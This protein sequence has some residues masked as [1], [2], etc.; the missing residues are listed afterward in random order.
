MISKYFFHHL[1][2]HR[3]HFHVYPK[4]KLVLR[5]WLALDR[6]AAA[7]RRVFYSFM[8]TT[9]DLAIGG[10]ILI[11]FFH[12]H[13]VIVVGI[14]FLLLAGILAVFSYRRYVGVR[15]HYHRLAREAAEHF[16]QVLARRPVSSRKNQSSSAST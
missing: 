3:H 13:W 9:L 6:T 11:R 1:D 7:N 4:S 2:A 15:S 14:L 16:P 5:D 12:Y 8:R 10:L